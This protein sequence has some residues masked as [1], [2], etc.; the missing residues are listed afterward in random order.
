MSNRKWKSRKRKQNKCKWSNGTNIHHR[1]AISLG[2]DRVTAGGR[3]NLIR[4]S[5]YSHNAFN[6]VF[7]GNPTAEQICEV[8]NQ[9][10]VNPDFEIKFICERKPNVNSESFVST[11]RVFSKE[12]PQGMLF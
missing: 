12:K 11:T 10:W 3:D 4:V 2:G 6:R 1:C 5:I 9:I 7:G 8:L